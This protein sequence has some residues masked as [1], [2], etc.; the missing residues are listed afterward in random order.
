ML[1]K[2]KGVKR[3]ADLVMLNGTAQGSLKRCSARSQN[4]LID[5]FEASQATTLN[6]ASGDETMV[7]L[8]E[9]SGKIKVLLLFF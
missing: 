9:A 3:E 7:L 6:Y 4:F 5:W 1:D 2:V 8:F